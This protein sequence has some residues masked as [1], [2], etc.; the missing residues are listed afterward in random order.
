MIVKRSQESAAERPCDGG[1]VGGAEV[2]GEV[3]ELG[4]ALLQFDQAEVTQGGE[5]AE[6][7]LQAPVAHG[8]RY[9][10]VRL[11]RLDRRPAEARRQIASVPSARIER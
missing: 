2:H 3:R 5:L 7:H 11:R 6:E 1:E 9:R 8:R 10:A 4:G